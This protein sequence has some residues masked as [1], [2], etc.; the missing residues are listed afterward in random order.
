[1]KKS[2]LLAAALLS[3][4]QFTKATV[5][6]VTTGAEF[7]TVFAK[8]GLT[9]ESRDT[10]YINA[11]AEGCN[12]GT[13]NCSSGGKNAFHHYAYDVDEE[14][15]PTTYYFYWD[16]QANPTATPHRGNI[17]FIGRDDEAGNKAVLSTSWYYQNYDTVYNMSLIFDNLE[18]QDA[19]HG[20]SAKSYLIR[21]DRDTQYF[22][23]IIFRNC[24]FNKLGDYL[25]TFKPVQV[26]KYFYTP[27]AGQVY[28]ET[29]IPEYSTNNT[30]SVYPSGGEI[31][32]FMM[33]NCKWH[34]GQLANTKL[35]DGAHH[36]GEIDIL[37][38]TFYNVPNFSSLFTVNYLTEG[39][40]ENTVV[41]FENNNWYIANGGSGVLFNYGDKWGPQSE[42]HFTNNIFMYPNWVD[43]YNLAWGTYTDEETFED[44][45]NTITLVNAYEAL[46]YFTNNVNDGCMA[47]IDKYADRSYGD[48]DEPNR[49]KWYGCTIEDNYTPEEMELSFDGMLNAQ[50]GSFEM[51]NTI[52]AATGGEG[53]SPLGNPAWYVSKLPAKVQFSAVLEGTTVAE[54]TISPVRSTYYEDDVIS[55]YVDTHNLSTF[56]G[57][58]DGNTDNPR[59]ITLGTEDVNL[60]GTCE[61]ASFLAV[62]NLDNYTTA[63]YKNNTS[64]GDKPGLDAT[65][66]KIG[67]AYISYMEADD[68]THVFSTSNVVTDTLT[69]TV[70]SADTTYYMEMRSG[71][72]ESDQKPCY[73]VK[74]AVEDYQAGKG[75]HLMLT[76]CTTGQTGISVTAL[77]GTDGY[78][79][80]KVLVDYSLDGKTWSNVGY[81]NIHQ[82]QSWYEVSAQLPTEADNQE[83]V[84][85][86]FYGD[87]AAA[88]AEDGCLF[89]YVSE[90]GTYLT[91]DEVEWEFWFLTNIWITAGQQTSIEEIGRD[92]APKSSLSFDLNGRRQNAQ[93][94]LTI[95]NG[96][97]MFVK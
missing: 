15:K 62:W 2:L 32:L 70:L 60:V 33:D 10:V 81:G 48:A 31:G 93:F 7:K 5:Y 14:G 91:I 44:K 92:A 41:F 54:L 37:N 12:P 73:A 40:S 28:D 16:A 53:G 35:Y 51:L 1:M 76:F 21:G 3:L 6:E 68:E 36:F 72:C 88:S 84:Y 26:K 52:K 65:Y 11:S 47:S 25:F 87:P 27:V 29:N 46:G 58:S 74:T 20:T 69:G 64:L 96:R 9:D 59:I 82:S 50:D 86:R 89:P 45:K 79:A 95:R 23:S 94:G 67:T 18:I 78:C 85:V 57:W 55:L 66:S 38:S 13:I 61:D 77:A 71:K 17:W 24:D 19:T 22:D 56:K 97:V 75:R 39:F 8:I 83:V 34:N 49:G 63:G 30:E 42:F 4:G 43:D 90:D 80:K